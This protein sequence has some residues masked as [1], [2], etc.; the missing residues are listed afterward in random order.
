MLGQGEGKATEQRINISFTRPL[1]PHPDLYQI[2]HSRLWMEG[3][4]LSARERQDVEG[5]KKQGS[6]K[7]R[8]KA[9]NFSGVLAEGSVCAQGHSLRTTVKWKRTDPLEPH[10]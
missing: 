9:S 6:R 5:E 3:E 10:W 4:R 7:Q 1:L 8:H 2:L